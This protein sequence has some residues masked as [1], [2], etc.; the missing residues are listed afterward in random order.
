M[1]AKRSFGMTSPGTWIFLPV[2]RTEGVIVVA[3]IEE[4]DFK[5]REEGKGLFRKNCEDPLTS[6]SVRMMS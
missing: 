5:V 4:F 3:S 2:Y 1:A 6:R